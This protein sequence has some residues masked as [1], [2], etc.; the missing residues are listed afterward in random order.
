M[1]RNKITFFSIVMIGI[2]KCNSLGSNYEF[3]HSCIIQYHVFIHV[4]M[5]NTIIIIHG[6]VS[7][8]KFLIRFT[9]KLLAVYDVVRAMVK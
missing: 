9:Q 8:R 6:D 7:F 1:F 2:F 4:Q 3:M 5:Y